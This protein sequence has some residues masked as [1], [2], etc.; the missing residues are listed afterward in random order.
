MFGLKR[1]EK[2]VVVD[3]YTCVEVISK[4][5]PIAP[6]KEFIPQWFKDIPAK[7]FLEPNQLIG[8]R[9]VRTCA[10][11]TD[12]FKAGVVLPTWCEM[13]VE[14][15]DNTNHEYRY[16]FADK[17]SEML[18]PAKFALDVNKFTQLELLTPWAFRCSEDVD[19]MIMQNVYLQDHPFD[20]Y[21]KAKVHNFR[22]THQIKLD[23]V[24]PRGDEGKVIRIPDGQPLVQIVPLTERPV[25]F[26]VHLVDTPTLIS[27]GIKSRIAFDDDYK[28]K[29]N[30]LS[31]GNNA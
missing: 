1:R 18:K 16:Q 9:T 7:L 23:L 28:A 17:A 21:P 2:P 19:F 8:H 27:K 31:G 10:G 30:R 24:F 6:T 13:V 12:I 22:D 29:K 25:E 4:Y 11:I 20:Y 26:R 14:L 15:R 3:C 5:Y